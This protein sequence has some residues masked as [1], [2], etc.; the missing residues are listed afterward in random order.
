MTLARTVL[1]SD[2]PKNYWHRP[3]PPLDIDYDFRVRLH[4]G[5][6]RPIAV[7]ALVEQLSWTDDGPVMTGD[8]TFREPPYVTKDGRKVPLNVGRGDRFKVFTS[9]RGRNRWSLLWEMRVQ[10]P[11]G[12]GESVSSDIVEGAAIFQLANDLALLSE[13]HDDWHFTTDKKHKK[14]WRGDQIVRYVCKRYGV[15][16]G[17]LPRMKSRTKRLTRKNT[18]P[19]AIIALAF[20]KE[21]T[22][23]GKRY[24]LGLRKGKLTAWPYRRSAWLLVLGPLISQAVYGESDRADFATEL[25]VRAGSGKTKKKKI[26]VKV[27]SRG[28][29]KRFGLI[30]KNF[31]PKH[32]DTAAEARRAGKRELVKRLKPRREITLSHPGIPQLARGH[33]ILL[34]LKTELGLRQILYVKSVSHRVSSG[35]YTMD[36]TLAFDDP[37]E[38]KN[39]KESLED[40]CRKAR[41]QG[42]PLPEGCPKKKTPDAAPKPVLADTRADLEEAA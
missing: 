5:S 32:V 31:T 26:H 4:R 24:F 3:R 19:L 11:P 22:Q 33:A 6:R 18:S 40:R 42:K 21:R 38:N 8:L 7:D 15:P 29:I 41:E 12:G 1:R 34:D 9:Q 17:P 27:R 20:R 25:V 16:V 13:S 30:R 36:P 28:A 2:A 10:P 14:G 37:F 23:T 35:D 39:K